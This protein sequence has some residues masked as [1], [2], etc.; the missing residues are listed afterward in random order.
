[1]EWERGCNC[2]PEGEFLP[3]HGFQLSCLPSAS[4]TFR[5]LRLFVTMSSIP[6]GV[7]RCSGKVLFLL[8]SSWGFPCAFLVRSHLTPTQLPFILQAQAPSCFSPNPL[9][10]I[11]CLISFV[12]I[13]ALRETR[14]FCYLTEPSSEL[15]VIWFKYH[16]LWKNV[17]AIYWPKKPL[18]EH[19]RNSAPRP[20]VPPR[21]W[22]LIQS[23]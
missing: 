20:T 22:W 14:S 8:I 12:L 17:R 10:I 19:S 11:S 15:K 13:L 6:P 23:T 21:I 5:G 16:H 7:W 9:Q 1:M 4:G 2:Q 3:V 18:T